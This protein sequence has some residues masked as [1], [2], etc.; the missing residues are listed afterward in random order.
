MNNLIISF[1][2]LLLLSFSL[3]GC[4][5]NG[6]NAQV[7]EETKQ[8]FLAD[9]IS[10]EINANEEA[11]GFTLELEVSPNVIFIDELP[12]K[13]SGVISARLFFDALEF[14][15]PLNGILTFRAEDGSSNAYTIEILSS[16]YNHVTGKVIISISQLDQDPESSQDSIELKDLSELETVFGLAFLFIDSFSLCPAGSTPTYP[17][18]GVCISDDGSI[19]NGSSCI[20][21]SDCPS[22]EDEG[23]CLAQCY[24]NDGAIQ[25]FV[26]GGELDGIGSQIFCGFVCEEG[27]GVLCGT[28]LDGLCTG[29]ASQCTI[30]DTGLNTPSCPPPPCDCPSGSNCSPP[31][32]PDCLPT[33]LGL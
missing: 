28:C 7:E 15:V 14:V 27:E 6:A 25:G 20:D 4:N 30:G 16:D 5:D 2:L 26:C 19:I 21:D 32:A 12:A 11:K 22:G 17:N 24:G 1:G 18:P 13:G 3:S 33:G 8:D 31:G 9:I 10:G 23:L 29:V